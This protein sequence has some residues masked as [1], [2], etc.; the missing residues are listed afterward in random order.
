MWGLGVVLKL[1][2]IVENGMV[3]QGNFDMYDLLCM[4]EI[5]EVE[6]YIIESEDLLLGIGEL[7]VLGVVFV[8]FNVI[9]VVIGYC[10]RCIF[11][12]EELQ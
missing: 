11:V 4:K 1:G 9:Y 7:V 5:L 2:I 3:Q 6:V 8:V 12:K 10:L